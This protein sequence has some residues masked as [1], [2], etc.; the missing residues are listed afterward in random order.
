MT[1]SNERRRL[2]QQNLPVK[3]FLSPTD[4]WAVM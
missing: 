4:L 3:T 2:V 1:S